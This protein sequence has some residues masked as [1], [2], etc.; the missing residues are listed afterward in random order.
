MYVK[1]ASLGAQTADDEAFWNKTETFKRR[2]RDAT[3]NA[4]S[5]DNVVDNA[6]HM[7]LLITDPFDMGSNRIAPDL[8]MPHFLFVVDGLVWEHAATTVFSPYG[9][10]ELENGSRLGLASGLRYRRAP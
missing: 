8:S 4:A 6:P 2:W 1:L 5:L 10:Q 9:P 7:R 3:C